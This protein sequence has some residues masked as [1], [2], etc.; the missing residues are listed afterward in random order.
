MVRRRCSC[1]SSARPP[2]PGTNT[3]CL[4]PRA[5]ALVPRFAHRHA[6]ARRLL[7]D[8]TFKRGYC[9]M[10][11]VPGR[12]SGNASHTGG[13]TFTYDNACRVYL[14]ATCHY[15]CHAIDVTGV[16]GQLVERQ[17][18]LVNI[19]TTQACTRSTSSAAGA[20]GAGSD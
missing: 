12:D 11:D 6:L 9:K 8:K 10:C 17:G 2:G 7:L 20:V 4:S 3:A 5:T 1:H 16:V 14:C 13:R 19:A 15:D 18:C